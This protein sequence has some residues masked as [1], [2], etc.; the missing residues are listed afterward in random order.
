MPRRLLPLLAA[1]AVAA[2]FPTACGR[3]GAGVAATAPTGP[4]RW[5]A[6]RGEIEPGGVLADLKADAPCRVYLSIT[7]EGSEASNVITRVLAAGESA[8]IW[9][10]GSVEPA[11][12]GGTSV[13]VADSSVGRTEGW[14]AVLHY[15]W[16]DSSSTSYAM[17]VGTRPG[18]GSKRGPRDA[19]PPVA[20]TIV[21]YGE[22]VELCAVAVLDGGTADVALVAGARGARLQGELDEAAGDRA[23]VLRLLMRVERVTP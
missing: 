4:A 7:G 10:R 21:P 11:L 23:Q 5:S 1:L 3:E 19:L 8:R 12:G 13:S 14:A 16:Q 18:R 22:D 15:G 6:V 9:W 17:I 20:A 2:G